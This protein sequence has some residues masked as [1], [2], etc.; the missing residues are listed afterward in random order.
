MR[1]KRKA[2]ASGNEGASGKLVFSTMVRV[3][4]DDLVSAAARRRRDV[5]QIVV[6]IVLL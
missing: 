3:R 6:I 2:L 1:E 5:N 4:E